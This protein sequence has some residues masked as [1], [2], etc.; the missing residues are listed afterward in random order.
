MVCDNKPGICVGESAVW[1]S[2]GLCASFRVIVWTRSISLFR[3]V[4]FS[5]STSVK[6][7]E[8][9]GVSSLQRSL[10]VSSDEQK[11]RILSCC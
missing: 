10:N 9:Y 5:V 7:F 6:V 4:K 1:V 3:K 2:L 8:R 11:R